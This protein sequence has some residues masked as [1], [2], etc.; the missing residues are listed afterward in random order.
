MKQH[1]GVNMAITRAQEERR[2]AIGDTDAMRRAL[3][4][5]HKAGELV[6]PYRNL[7]ISPDYWHRLNACE[8]SLHVVRGL[9][10]LHP[11]WVF[12][13][14]TAADVYGFDHSWVLHD[15]AVYV[16]DAN[17]DGI[18]DRSRLS[19]GIGDAG[20]SVGSDFG[21]HR[22]TNGQGL[23]MAATGAYEIRRLYIPSVNKHPV[24]GITV[25]DPARTLI[26]CALCMQFR[27][28]L[29]LFDSAARKGVGMAS[30]R[31]ACKG[32]HM[33][34]API[35][36]L[37]RY[38]DGRSENGGESLVRATIIIGGFALPQLQVEI[39][40]PSYPARRFRVDFL[41]KLYDGR[42]IV[43]EY[44]GMAKYEDVSMTHGRTAKQV[45]NEQKER[46]RVLYAAG[47]TSILHCTYEDVCGS[48][49][50]SVMLRDA[51][52]PLIR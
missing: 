45:L 24:N 28:A 38:A 22:V 35:E 13:G 2:C 19:M 30:V 11:L 15:D 48:N 47:V 29:A 52:V 40:D 46:D 36:M 34:R 3:K 10:I 7:Y 5:R 17:G 49:R 50:L 25:T 27:Y 1:K 4:R 12:A 51:G 18:V 6:S 43:L 42:V 8:R 41:W 16:A 14:L 39:R 9:L 32:L 44:D 26:D 33:D 37:T 20:R 31:D 23:G 21:G